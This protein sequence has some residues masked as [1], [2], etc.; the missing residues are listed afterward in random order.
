MI[1][2]K[3]GKRSGQGD[4]EAEAGETEFSVYS[5]P[6]D[7]IR[8]LPAVSHRKNQSPPSAKS[9]VLH[10]AQTSGPCLWTSL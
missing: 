4:E 9:G 7:G 10:H 6:H 8:C 1:Q 2:I 3:Q 5:D